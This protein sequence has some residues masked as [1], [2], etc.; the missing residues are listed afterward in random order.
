MLHSD[1]HY[2]DGYPIALLVRGAALCYVAIV[3]LLYLAAV[4]QYLNT[5]SSSA[6]LARIS[7]YAGFLGPTSVFLGVLLWDTVRTGGVRVIRIFSSIGLIIGPLALITILALAFNFHPTAYWGERGDSSLLPFFA[8]FSFLYACFGATFV[9][10]PGVVRHYRLIFVL[11]IVVLFFSQ[12]LYFLSLDALSQYEGRAAGFAGNPNFG[13]QLLLALTIASV[14][15]RRASLLNSIV[16]LVAGVGVFLTL[17]RGGVLEFILALCVYLV[18]TT[19]VQART[20]LTQSVF[21]AILVLILVFGL[22]SLTQ[23]LT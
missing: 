19:R 11:C 18:V 14:D 10:I 20:L 5:I 16:W 7:I 6:A 12:L 23:L 8:L 1:R 4:A 3:L 22:P 21:A 17:S 13:A 9:V 2:S 15:W